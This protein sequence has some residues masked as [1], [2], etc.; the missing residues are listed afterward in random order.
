MGDL[1]GR[2]GEAIKRRRLKDGLSQEDLAAKAD[3]HPTFLSE[4]ENGH[5]DLRLSSICKVADGL[6]VSVLELI[7][8]AERTELR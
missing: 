7:G 4:L 3:L 1:Q 8:L 5:K 2:L 6:G